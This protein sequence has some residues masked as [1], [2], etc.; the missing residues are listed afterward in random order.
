MLERL[1]NLGFVICPVP[2]VGSIFYMLWLQ[3]LREIFFFLVDIPLSTLLA[4]PAEC[5]SGVKS[6]CVAVC[7]FGNDSQMAVDALRTV[8]KNDGFDIKDL[9]GGL[10]AWSTT[11]D[12]Q[13]PIY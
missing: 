1:L 7:R 3:M 10:V 2:S 8:A 4:N 12:N 11:V 5:F 13:F 6:T 9:I